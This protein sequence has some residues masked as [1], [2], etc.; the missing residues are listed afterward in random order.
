LSAVPYLVE[1][2]DCRIHPALAELIRDKVVPA[3]NTW[4]GFAGILDYLLSC[5]EVILSKYVLDI[6]C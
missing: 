1:S 3:H 5:L 2:F 6:I 4:H